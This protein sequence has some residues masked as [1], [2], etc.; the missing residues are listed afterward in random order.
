MSKTVY[1]ENLIDQET[2]EII[3]RRWITKK[4]TNIDHFMRTYVEDIGILSECSGCE[5][6]LVLAILKYVEY[7]TNKI[8]LDTQRKEEICKTWNI[9]RNTFNT[10]ISRLCKKEI[11]FR[12]SN[13]AY[14]LNPQLFFYGPDI[15]REKVFELVIRYQIDPS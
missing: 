3:P 9:K 6:T 2:G 8:F 1:T 4:Q 5:R 11:L 12:S 10:A 14:T 7:K 15:E 13:V